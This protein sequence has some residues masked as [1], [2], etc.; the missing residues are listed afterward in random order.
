RPDCGSVPTR[1]SS[2]LGAGDLRIGVG[3]GG[4]LLLAG[5]GVQQVAG[6]QGAGGAVGLGF[7]PA[8]AEGGQGAA[9]LDQAVVGGAVEAAQDQRARPGGGQGERVGVDRG[10]VGARQQQGGGVDLRGQGLGG[11]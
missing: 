11:G 5:E 1:R 8:R 6:D 10:D 4:V 7:V 9:A 2:D 3:E